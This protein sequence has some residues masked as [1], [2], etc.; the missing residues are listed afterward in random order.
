[1]RDA[2]V[3]GAC[4]EAVEEV[5]D[6]VV[7]ASVEEHLAVEAAGELQAEVVG[8]IVFRRQA[9]LEAGLVEAGIVDEAHA[10]VEEQTGVAAGAFADAPLI[11]GVGRDIRRGL[12]LRRAAGELIAGVVAFH[13]EAVLE[14]V[15]A[16]EVGDLQRH[17]EAADVAV[18]VLAA[19]V[20]EGDAVV[21]IGQRALEDGRRAGDEDEVHACAIVLPVEGVDGVV[22]VDLVV[23]AESEDTHLAAGAAVERQLAVEV[24]VVEGQAALDIGVYLLGGVGEERV[25]G[26]EEVGDG[27]L[28]L[29]GLAFQRTFEDKTGAE[30]VEAQLAGM[31]FLVSVAGGDVHH[32][33]ETAAVFGAEATGVD[34]GV[35]DDVGLEDRV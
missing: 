12:L 8:D 28:R 26:A 19:A 5:D 16:D 35:E 24:E 34:I 29:G 25:L 2:E 4:E 21:G 10:G 27:G 23:E 11:G 33:T 7:G 3:G 1:M 6:V 14:S 20:V 15:T 18:A 22:A 30:G 17:V 31:V 13:A 32:R 9:R